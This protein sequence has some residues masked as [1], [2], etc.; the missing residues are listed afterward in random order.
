MRIMQMCIFPILIF[1]VGC[2]TTKPK[3]SQLQMREFQTKT[4]EADMKTTMKAM[5]AVLQDDSYMLKEANLD[6]GLITAQKEVDVQDTGAAVVAVLFAGANA[7]W[8]KN[9][10]WEATANV[11]EYGDKCK[12]RVTFQ[13]KKMNNKG[14]V[15]EVQQVDTE[16]HYVEFFDK[17]D[18]AIFLQKEGL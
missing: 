4:T 13:M 10:I 8:A 12:V 9:S 17:V 15:M 6:L 18:K 5:M 3:V 16:N 7:R 11:T 14:E 2:A 1:A